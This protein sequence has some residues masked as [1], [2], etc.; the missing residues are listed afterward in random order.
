MYT[1][2]EPSMPFSASGCGAE[3]LRAVIVL[4][5]ARRREIRVKD[6]IVD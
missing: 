6:F 5:R 1:T 4:P 3:R 2:S